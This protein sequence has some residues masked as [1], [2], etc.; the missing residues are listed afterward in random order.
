[1]KAT[2]MLKRQHREVE[3]LFA[4]AK[5]ATS[6]TDRRNVVAQIEEKLRT[7]MMIEEHI[8]YPAVLAA[9]DKK[10]TKAL[11]PEAYEE[12]HVIN[13]LL[14]ELP[15]LGAQ[16]E[17]FAPKITVLCELVE[18]HVE[19]EEQEMFPAAERDLDADALG[20]LA[21]QMQAAMDGAPDAAD[22]DAGTASDEDEDEEEAEEDG[23]EE[24]DEDEA[25]DSSRD[26]SDG[27]PRR[28]ATR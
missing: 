22:G 2:A 7:H 16:D 20:D 14:A 11:I 8:F 17:R 4:Q 3:A 25:G 1:M 26:D 18:H 13:L 19:E 5:K 27:P 15:E 12:H 6:A 9:T 24:E 21:E 28:R 10:T 23:D